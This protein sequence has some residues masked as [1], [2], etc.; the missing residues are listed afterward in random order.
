MD[1]RRYDLK[2]GGNA[3]AS[4]DDYLEYRRIVGDDDGGKLF[5]PEEYEAYKKKV[6]PQRMKNRVFTSWTNNS[7]MDCKQ[8]GPETPCFCQ[9][10]YKQHRTDFERIPD[11]RPIMLPCQ[12][13][14]CKCTSYHYV[15]LMGSSPIRC[16]CKHPADEHS[17]ARPHLC[18]K[19]IC[20][21]CS[22]FKSSYTCGCGE[23][24]G[25]HEMIVETKAEREARGHPVGLDTPYQAMGGLTGFSSLAEGYMRL[26]PS[27]R[28]A[29]TDE[30]LSQEIT[31]SDHAFLRG[32]VPTLQA[33][34]RANKDYDR[35]D[36]DLAE[37]MS[38]MRRPGESELD[39]Y[40]RRYQERLKAERTGKRG[41]QMSSNQP[42]TR[43]GQRKPPSTT[44][45]S[46]MTPGQKSMTKK[47]PAK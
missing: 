23:P 21:N 45:S 11:A 3:A 22:G 26:D 25:R 20:Q 32:H 35:L 9:H 6:L 8:V 33:V 14:G 1:D 41:I 10:R 46:G 40:E 18:M 29:P 12:V 43:T 24:Y 30:F 4:V 31:S 44:N 2:F 13:K 34:R 39:F 47:A 36:E 16:T 37:R 15:P 38:A 27:G 28:G 42:S 17:P 7:G 5:T 19:S